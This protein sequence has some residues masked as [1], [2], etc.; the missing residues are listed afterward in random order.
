MVNINAFDIG[1]WL[2]SI[3]IILN[4]LPAK[5]KLALVLF[6]DLTYHSGV[7]KDWN[8]LTLTPAGVR[9]L[10]WVIFRPFAFKRNHCS[11]I[12]YKWYPMNYRWKGLYLDK[13]VLCYFSLQDDL[14]RET[15]IKMVIKFCDISNPSKN[16]E[17]YM[18]WTRLITEEFYLQGD[19][20]KKRGLKV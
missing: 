20:E 3:E 19:E 8:S 11:F 12:A 1:I 4:I 9:A 7:L 5:L 15:M 16:W 6:K 18:R 14:T 13:L 2:P 10:K 17:N